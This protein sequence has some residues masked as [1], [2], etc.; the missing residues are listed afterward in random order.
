ML[1]FDDLF[2]NDFPKKFIV[3]ETTPDKISPKDKDYVDKRQEELYRLLSAELEI[4][5]H[6]K[7]KLDRKYIPTIES[8]R[9]EKGIIFL[10]KTKAGKKLSGY[11]FVNFPSKKIYNFRHLYVDP[12]IDDNDAVRFTA[13]VSE[14]LMPRGYQ[15]SRETV[16]KLGY[17]W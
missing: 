14:M 3:E 13:E 9:K 10:L 17:G 2:K 1:S 15:M 6:G 4:R 7:T 11:V 16:K 5:T 12:S 8:L